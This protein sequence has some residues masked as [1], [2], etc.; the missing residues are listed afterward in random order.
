MA[1]ISYPRLLSSAIAKSFSNS[2]LEFLS[3]PVFKY[4]AVADDSGSSLLAM[5]CHKMRAGDSV[6]A[7]KFLN[8]LDTNFTSL[9]L[10]VF[11]LL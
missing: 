2:I 1:I 9:R 3:D 10:S 6:H 5:R 4:T 7:S 8:K 11:G